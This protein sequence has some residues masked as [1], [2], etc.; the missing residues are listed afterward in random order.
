MKIV[1]LLLHIL[2]TL[3]NSFLK[4][5]FISKSVDTTRNNYVTLHESL[6]KWW[7][8]RVIF[9]PYRGNII[10]LIKKY[11]RK[12]LQINWTQYTYFQ[13]KYF[14]IRMYFLN[15]WLEFCFFCFG[16]VGNTIFTLFLFKSE[17]FI[18]SHKYYFPIT[19]TK[20]LRLLVIVD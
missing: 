12:L 16:K 11:K 19:K 13:V 15:Y 14:E 20:K 4:F 2:F 10:I 1:G 5:Y 17:I 3:W 6:F 8:L 7:F 18:S 9:L